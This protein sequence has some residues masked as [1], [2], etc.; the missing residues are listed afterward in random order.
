MRPLLLLLIL[1]V[2]LLSSG[3][4]GQRSADG[5]GTWQ[6]TELFFGLSRRGA[7]DVSE[8]EWSEFVATQIAPAFPGGFT[9]LTAIG[10]FRQDGKS[11]SEPVRVL[12]ILNPPEQAVSTDSKLN[13][14][15]RAYCARFGQD[16]VLRS[17][18]SATLTFLRAHD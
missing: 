2:P 6:R 1:L 18:S 5:S 14:L 9:E 17:D 15:G 7:A 12:V 4:Q 13:A 3:C 11:Q 8:A 16:A 10:H